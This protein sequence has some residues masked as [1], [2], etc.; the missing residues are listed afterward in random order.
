MFKALIIE[1][2][3]SDTEYTFSEWDEGRGYL[4]VSYKDV[5]LSSEFTLPVF[6]RG[7]WEE[8][9]RAGD[10]AFGMMGDL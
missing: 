6:T 1:M 2:H 4:E 7:Q 8:F 5:A 10:M 3:E 9:K